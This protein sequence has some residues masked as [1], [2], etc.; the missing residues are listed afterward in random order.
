MNALKFFR[1]YQLM[2]L[3]FGAILITSCS[4][5]D[6]ATV[7]NT[8]GMDNMDG[9]DMDDDAP[10]MENELEVITDVTVIFTNTEDADDVVMA[11]AQDP[12]GEGVM[13]LM[14]DGDIDLT[15]GV[16]YTLTFEILNALDPDDV[17]DIGEEILDEDDEHQIF[18]A[19][20]D[21]AFT[22]P[23]GDGNIG[24]D[25]AADPINYMDEDS[26]M[27]D[28]SGNPIG[29]VTEWTAGT[30]L[31][32]GM[33]TV[34]LQHQPD[35]KSA[36]TTS[37]DGDTDFDLTF[38]LNIQ[39]DPDAP[40]AENEVEV[41]TDVTLIF[42][43]TADA[44]DVVMATAQD[45][46]G[47]GVLE[48]EVDGPINL[49]SGVTYNLTFDIFNNLESPGEDIGAEIQEEDDEHQIFFAF[50]DGAFTSPMGD[51]NI[52][53]GN[54]ADPINYLDEDSVMQDG[55]GNPVGLLTE[56]TAGAALMDGMFT[57]RLQHQPDLKSASTTSED[58]DTDFDLT[59]VLNIQ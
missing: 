16:T 44:N 28:G 5:D 41:I 15:E 23:M 53:A 54:A 58:G 55:S 14:V 48:L 52:G 24:A 39:E 36:T 9:M 38:V 59:F 3:L 25:S 26:E 20:T 10:P 42:T 29:L 49:T 4:D 37:E 31:M 11:S 18:F 30:A 50:S 40:P 19:F 17:E 35:L 45:P 21:G 12:D 56:W 47:Q 2:V 43:N 7:D 22:S 27:Q 33:F 13:E 1:N 46:D 57:V 32:D 51:G 34:R 8:D 6:D